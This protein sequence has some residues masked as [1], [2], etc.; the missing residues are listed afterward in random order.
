MWLSSAAGYLS[1]HVSMNN[2]TVGDE[3]KTLRDEL[4]GVLSEQQIIQSKFMMNRCL[5]EREFNRALLACGVNAG[6]KMHRFAG[7]KIHQWCWQEGLRTGGRCQA[8][9]GLSAGVSELV[10]RERCLL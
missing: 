8:W 2:G 6:A 7:A 4:A 10:R 1:E 3:A 9:V 5:E